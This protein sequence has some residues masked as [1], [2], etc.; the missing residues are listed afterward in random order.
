[1]TYKLA[2]SLLLA[3]M[4]AAPM[5][6]FAQKDVSVWMTTPDKSS[7]LQ[8]QATHPEFATSAATGPVISVDA[9]QTY[10]AIDGFGFALTGGSAELMMKMSPEKRSALI[11][12]LFGSDGKSIGVSYL[13]VSVGSSDMNDHAFSYDDLPTGETDPKLEKFSFGPD[14]STVIP[15]LQEILKVNPKIKILASPW[16]APPWMKTTHAA[17]AGVLLPEYYGAY[18]DYLVKYIAGMKAAGIDIDTLTVQNEP[19]NE[20]N[21]PSM[22]MLAPEQADFIAN[23]LGPAFAKADIK[24]KIVLY[25]HNCDHPAYPLLI[26]KDPAASKYVDGS[27][28]HLY[29]GKIEALS[30]V[31]N[32][33][34]NKNLY[35]TEQSISDFNDEMNIARTV[36]WVVIGATRNWS[37]NVLLWNLAADPH[38]GPHTNNGGCTECQGAITIDHDRVIRHLAYYTIAQVSKFVPAGSVRIGSNNL[39]PLPNVAFRTPDGKT[40]LVVANTSRADQNFSVREGGRE[41]NTSLSTG[42][43]AT[44]IW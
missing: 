36:S 38:F 19:L 27:G 41:F 8:L 35:F 24:T 37:R 20:K 17:K 25:D 30:E 43:A 32:A 3:A 11:Q 2:G 44:Y 29:G 14:E 13:R 4:I 23:D 18:A 16:S 22:L 21:T 9:K 31:H 34:P 10:Q 6:L 39:D 1:M 7:L 26:L 5:S 40:A 15:V 42:A 33:F 28:F 12:E